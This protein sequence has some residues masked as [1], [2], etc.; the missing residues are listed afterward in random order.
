MDALLAKTAKAA[1]E[2]KFERF[3]TTNGFDG[4]A[5]NPVWSGEPD[6]G[7]GS[8]ISAHFRRRPGMLEQVV[9]LEN[10]R[11]IWAEPVS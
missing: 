8:P 5:K 1:S 2:G 9:W 4:T 7:P 3:K 11:R 6:E 10:C